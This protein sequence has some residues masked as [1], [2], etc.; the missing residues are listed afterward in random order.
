MVLVT[1]TVVYGKGDEAEMAEEIA[2]GHYVEDTEQTAAQPTLPPVG[3]WQFVVSEL[4]LRRCPLA[5]AQ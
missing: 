5:T 3:E 2:E 1:G 4:R